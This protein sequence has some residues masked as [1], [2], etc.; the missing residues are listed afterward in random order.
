MWEQ[1]S[2]NAD[3][4]LQESSQGHDKNNSI[5][6]KALFNCRPWGT[7]LLE[8]GPDS[9][10]LQNETGS[11]CLR[12]LGKALQQFCSIGTVEE[13]LSRK[14]TRFLPVSKHCNILYHALCYSVYPLFDFVATFSA[15]SFLM[16]CIVFFCVCAVCAVYA[17]LWNS[18]ARYQETT[19]FGCQNSGTGWRRTDFCIR[20]LVSQLVSLVRVGR[21]WFDVSSG[22]SCCETQQLEVHN[23]LACSSWQ[24]YQNPR[25]GLSILISY[26]HVFSRTRRLSDL[27][28]QYLSWAPSHSKSKRMVVFWPVASDDRGSINWRLRVVD[29]VNGSVFSFLWHT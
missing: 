25:K 22:G 16:D 2:F 24:Q 11:N 4:P 15:I 23:C 21:S 6:F 26:L 28:C 13:A 29:A 12:P 18:A 9:K 14:L 27:S 17:C 7:K 3:S 8:N 5:N 1:R 10:P 20:Q 19:S